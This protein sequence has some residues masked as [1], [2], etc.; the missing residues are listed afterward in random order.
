MSDS[1][2]EARRRQRRALLAAALLPWPLRTLALPTA[3]QRLATAW[4]VDPPEAGS[5]PDRVGVLEID[6]AAARVRVAAEVPVPQRA[7][8]LL[9]LADGGFVA[10]A[11][12]P[13]RW[14][15][16]LDAAGRVQRQLNVDDETPRRSFNGHVE[17][18]AD[19]QW[20]FSTETDAATGQGW[21]SVRSAETLRRVAQF[22]T[23]GIDAHQL[24]RAP[25][26][27]L[28]VTNGGIVR[29][30]QGR[31]RDGEPMAPSLV[32]L[33]PA[34]GRV[35]GQWQLDDPQLSLRHLA[36]AEPQAPGAAPLLGVALQAEHD[37]AEARRNAPALALWDGRS[38]RLP[39]SD[40]AA[41]GYVGDICAGPN[42]GFIL[43][44]QKVGRC[45]WWQ[46][47]RPG[48]L[49]R[50]AELTEP[51]GLVA[52]STSGAA[53]GVLISAGRGLARWHVHDGA[54]MQRWPVAL[55]PDNHA[56]LLQPA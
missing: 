22:E 10:V 9:A 26:G 23:A 4:R 30:A 47:Q 40:A 7:H 42:G 18:S 55:A 14:L 3:P 28:L 16:R 37:S 35:L 17:L 39:C 56:V 51:C 52:E 8:G 46:P 15:M 38:L 12:R 21:V 45:L 49:Q 53:H 48:Q 34:S 36:W 5:A 31:K 13:G 43:S 25:D 54:A 20:L 27:T 29:D 50:M 44:A 32:Q 11:L 33:Q 1:N 2:D 41:A 19:G 24:L 6:W